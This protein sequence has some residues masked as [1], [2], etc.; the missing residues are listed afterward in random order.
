[1]TALNFSNFND[2]RLLD[3]E[4]F[5]KLSYKQQLELI[6]E[7]EKQKLSLYGDY[8]LNCIPLNIRKLKIREILED[9]GKN[10]ILSGEFSC[11][12]VIALLLAFRGG[13]SRD[14]G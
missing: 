14:F 6:T 11:L 7:Q 12:V 3:I 8:I 9:Q 4:N 2:D 13:E 10:I 1:M 5:I